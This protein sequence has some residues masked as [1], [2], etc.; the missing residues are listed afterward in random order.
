VSGALQVAATLDET[1]QQP[2]EITT[3]QMRNYQLHGM[4]WLAMMHANGMNAILADE[5]GLGK[6]LQTIAFLTHLKFDLGVPGPHLVVAPLSV[7][8]FPLC[9]AKRQAG[10]EQHPACY[11]C[12]VRCAEA[13]GDELGLGH[14]RVA[15][16]EGG[17]VEDDVDARELDGERRMLCLACALRALPIYRSSSPEL[18]PRFR[19]F[20][21]G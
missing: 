5:M 12:G 9:S 20:P 16:E 4:R 13:C 3:V 7:R 21:R 17:V 2:K 15:Q 11:G 18:R 6:T 1:L 8:R 10:C 19:C 14:A